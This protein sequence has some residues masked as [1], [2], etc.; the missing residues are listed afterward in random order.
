M[1]ETLMLTLACQSSWG[2]ISTVFLELV[3]RTVQS[4]PVI[5]FGP[6][7]TLCLPQHSTDASAAED[8]LSPLSVSSSYL[9]G[10]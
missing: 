5:V 10:S 8:A 4:G 6:S 1:L 2:Q 9:V 7:R 3:E